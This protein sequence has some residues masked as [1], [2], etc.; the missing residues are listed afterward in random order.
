MENKQ[1]QKYRARGKSF[2]L[3][4]GVPDRFSDTACDSWT[5]SWVEAAAMISVSELW[6]GSI[7]QALACLCFGIAR[8]WAHSWT[9]AYAN[10]SLYVQIAARSP[11]IS[12]D[13]GGLFPPSSCCLHPLHQTGMCRTLPRLQQHGE[14]SPPT[15][16]HPP[17]C[18]APALLTLEMP[19]SNLGTSHPAFAHK[20][21]RTR[22]AGRAKETT[23]CLRWREVAADPVLCLL[24]MRDWHES[25][26]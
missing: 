10:T 6:A 24:F 25:H 7:T 3:S 26:R 18:A 5:W 1:A 8:D 14:G 16:Q 21:T 19:H 13:F 23:Y 20:H 22:E 15:S 9:L 17:A 12:S 11:E 2:Q 4:H